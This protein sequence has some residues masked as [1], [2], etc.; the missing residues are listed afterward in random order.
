MRGLARFRWGLILGWAKGPAIG[1][2]LINARAESAA[3]KPAFRAAF[4]KRRCFVP[5]DGYYE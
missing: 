1:H 3:T 4:E 5:A 2:R